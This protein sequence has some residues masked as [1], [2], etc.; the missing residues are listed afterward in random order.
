MAVGRFA[1][2]HDDPPVDTIT[3]SMVRNFRRT[4]AAL[5]SRAGTTIAALPLLEQVE[6]ANA[7]GLKTLSPATVNK[8]LSAICVMLDNAVEE[9]EVIS[10]NVAKT[11]KSLAKNMMEDSRLP[12]GPQD[13]VKIFTADLPEKK[14]GFAMYIRLDV[15]PR[16]LHRMSA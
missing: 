5:P 7:Q 11:V 15:A 9:M 3:A 6:L 16:S 4:C 10:E 2:L 13:L 1:R 14:G 8:A 12:F